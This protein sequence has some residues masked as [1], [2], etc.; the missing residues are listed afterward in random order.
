MVSGV[1]TIVAVLELQLP[2]FYTPCKVDA[3]LV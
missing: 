3:M 1:I 2:D